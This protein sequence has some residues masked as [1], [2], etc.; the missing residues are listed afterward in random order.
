MLYPWQITSIQTLGYGNGEFIPEDSTQKVD[1]R[2]RNYLICI[3]QWAPI[4]QKEQFLCINA[5][6]GATEITKI[7]YLFA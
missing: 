6:N 3:Q 2:Y 1:K 5:I 7:R 4:L